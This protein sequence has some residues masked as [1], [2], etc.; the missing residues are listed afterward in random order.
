MLDH[1]VYFLFEIKKGE[2]Y[3]YF[4]K[5]AEILNFY[6]IKD[7]YIEKLNEIVI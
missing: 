4:K 7:H 1:Q 6:Q 2:N 3:I 5:L